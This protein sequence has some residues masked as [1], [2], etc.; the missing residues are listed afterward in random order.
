MKPAWRAKRRKIP[1]PTVMRLE[2]GDLLRRNRDGA[3]CLVMDR[4][5]LPNYETVGRERYRYQVHGN[6][7]IVYLNDIEIIAGFEVLTKHDKT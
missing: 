3:I 2:V 5:Y 6:G 1:P 7:A 4:E